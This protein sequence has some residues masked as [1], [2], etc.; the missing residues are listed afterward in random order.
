MQEEQ[1]QHGGEEEQGKQH[2]ELTEVFAL[3]PLPCHTHMIRAALTTPCGSRAASR[4][5]GASIV[6]MLSAP[7]MDMP[8]LQGVIRT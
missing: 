1:G 7:I 3:V 8:G 6:E 4:A 5:G 2:G